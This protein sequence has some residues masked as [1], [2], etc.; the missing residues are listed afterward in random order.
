M[1]QAVKFCDLFT[2][3][4]VP[5]LEIYIWIDSNEMLVENFRYTLIAAIGI[6]LTERRPGRDGEKSQKRQARRS[7]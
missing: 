7:N 2:P 1:K 4:I 5:P 6:N 3:L